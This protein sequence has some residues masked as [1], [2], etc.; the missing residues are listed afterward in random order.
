M[1]PQSQHGVDIV[2]FAKP[3]LI[4]MEDRPERLKDSLLELSDAARRPVTA[5]DL[6]LI[7]PREF[8]E[9]GGFA[10]TGFRSNLDAH[11]RAARWARAA[12]FERVLVMED[13]LSF[14]P[15]WPI[16]GAALLDRLADRRWH[17][18]NLGYLDVWN[19]AP[20]FDPVTGPGWLEFT[21]QVHGAHAYFIHRSG[22]DAWIAHL[23]AV[24]A[25]TPGDDLQGPMPSDG[26]INTFPWVNTETVRLLALPNMV[27]TR[28][29]RSDITPGMVDRLPLLGD[30]VEHL[31]AVRRRHGPK[32]TNFR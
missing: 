12:R 14:G 3:I 7:R 4:N 32:V 30:L 31:R 23:E 17:L 20:E 27:G 2:S 24:A 5:D 18:A 13:D 16:H 11:L 8:T 29:T 28:P 9:S 25:G 21:G 10:S 6:Q 15:M 26:A 22:L 19:R 1:N